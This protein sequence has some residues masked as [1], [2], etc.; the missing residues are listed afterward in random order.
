MKKIVIFP[1][2]LFYSYINSQSLLQTS[3]GVENSQ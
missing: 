1:I 3:D 2:L